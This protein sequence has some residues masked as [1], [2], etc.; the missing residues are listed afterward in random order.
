MI[1]NKLPVLDKGYVAIVD[2]SLSGKMMSK[3]EEEHFK[4]KINRDLLDCASL[5]LQIR[6]PIFFQVYLQQRRMTVVNTIEKEVEC[7]IPDISEINTGDHSVDK[8]IAEHMKQTIETILLTT[9]AFEKDK[10]DRFMSNTIIPVSVYNTVIVTASLTEWIKLID[11]KRKL[12]YAIKAY[13]DVIKD[14]VEAEWPKL[15]TYIKGL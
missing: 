8:D 9:K 1:L 4:G 5:T 14:A 3:L 11:G 13:T 10:L 6:C 2:S 12:P 7:Y 15:H